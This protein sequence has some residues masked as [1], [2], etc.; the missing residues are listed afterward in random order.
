MLPGVVSAATEIP[1]VVVSAARTEQSTLTTPASITVITREQ[2]EV[3]GARHINEVLRG[4]GGVQINDLYGDG[5]RATVDMR[6]FG[7][8]A[9]SNTLV[10]VDGRRLNNP[11]IAAPDLNSI[12]LEDVER[13]EIIQGSAGVLFGDQA[14]GGV[15]NVI[16]RK[17]GALRHSLKLSAG[18]YNTVQLHAMT[19]QALDNGIN[20]LLSVDARES[21]NY[22]DHNE[23]SYLNGLGKLGY[24]YDSGS[25]FGELQ[26]IN[27]EL[28]TPGPLFADQVIEDRRQV[29]PNYVDDFSNAK[30][31]IA[32]IGLVQQLSNNW[33]LEAELTGRDTNGEFRL[34]SMDGTQD[35]QVVEFT[36]RFI[37]FVPAMNNTMLTLGADAV[38]SDYK[39][40]SGF[41]DQLNDQMQGS[42]YAQAVIPASEVLDITLG[43]RYAE[44]ENELRDSFTFTSGQQIDDEVTVGTFGLAIKADENWR[45]LFRADQNYRFAKVDEYT[46]AL[47]VTTPPGVNILKTQEGVSIETGVEWAS[48]SDTAKLLIY[49]LDL[50]DEIAYDPVNFAN[51]NLDETRRKGVITSGYWQQSKKLGYSASYTFTDAEVLSGAFAGKDIPL[52]ARH[53]VLLGSDYQLT[54]K[55]QLYGELFA[56]SD[57]VFG[58]DF[59]NVLGRLPGYG[60]IN[61]KAGY[62][63]RDFSFTARINNLLNKAYSDVGQ[64]S[65]D[66]NTFA[67]TEA[68][69]TSPEIN[70]M[71]TAAWQ[72]R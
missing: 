17:P 28:N 4:Q 15:I 25:V 71:L 22:R 31:A 16:T 54:E 46:S 62:D 72:F 69:F 58:G 5:S 59:N 55:W 26:Y 6:G 43:V 13:I 51:I 2:I 66:P 3:S 18:S 70:F 9:G 27:E 29:S 10:L 56:I 19:S 39:L 32:R 61:I 50:D 45:I 57:R 35:R 21:D 68:F 37:G 36:P 48:G 53:S 33:S 34:V 52:V 14:V 23:A 40:S 64:L 41:G 49:Q 20:Y 44:V 67:A 30:T 8:T 63:H 47:P 7:D 42:L 12:A 1:A 24:E 11:D 38:D 60:I 65:Y